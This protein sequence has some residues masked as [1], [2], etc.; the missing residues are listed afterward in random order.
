M[1]L[2]TASK[3]VAYHFCRLFDYPLIKPFNLT[4][5][6]TDNCNSECKT[7]NI[8]KNDAK[9][10]SVNVWKKML[11]S[12]G[13]WPYWI[14]FSGG[15]PFL[16]KDLLEI[17]QHVTSICRPKIVTIA[18]NGM[19]DDISRQVKKM[20]EIYKKDLII[21]FSI[22][23]VK[24]IHEK[25]RGIKCFDKVIGNYNE[26]KDIEGVTV[27]MHAVLSKH[28]IDRL[29]DIIKLAEELAPDSFVCQIAEHRKELNNIGL[30]IIPDE[31]QIKNAMETLISYKRKAEGISRLTKALR[32]RYYWLQKKGKALP[33][34]AG[35]A[36]VQISSQGDVWACCVNCESMGNLQKDSF[37]NI[38]KGKKA[39]KIRK[40]IKQQKCSCRMANACYTNVICDPIR[41]FL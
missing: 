11:R 19:C 37:K 27:G 28:N 32:K 13:R 10:L 31:K 17:F 2:I 4:I 30:D 3:T 24:P 36:S 6:V 40:R 38:W 7:C 14:T 20:K 34:Y 35:L 18:T 15:E 21:N 5:S 9:D 26:V 23:G 39:S 33:C 25:M 16:R 8:W 1:V 41:A 29:D 12:V 22:D